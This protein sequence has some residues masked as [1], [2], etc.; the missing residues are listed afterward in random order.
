MIKHKFDIICLSEAYLNFERSSDISNLETAGY[1]IIRDNHAS[2]TR[3]WA[4]C[5]CYKNT[6][7]FKVI[8]IKC[9]QEF[10]LF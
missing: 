10:F 1:T 4:V 3:R 2:N 8:N 7:P 5:V 6:L 9:L